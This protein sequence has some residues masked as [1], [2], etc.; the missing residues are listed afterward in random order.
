M[1]S[2][3]VLPALPAWAQQESVSVTFKN[4]TQG[5]VR[6]YWLNNNQ[7]QLYQTLK[8][9]ESAARQTY[10]THVWIVRD[11]SDHELRRVT[12]AANTH[13]VLA[14]PSDQRGTPNVADTN[15][16]AGPTQ[17]Q[18]GETE[19]G[20]K[21][22][23]PA[24]AGAQVPPSSETI[25]A[26]REFFEKVKT[27][28]KNEP[29]TG[30]RH[31]GRSSLKPWLIGYSSHDQNP[32]AV[33]IQSL[34]QRYSKGWTF[35]GGTDY[36]E[37]SM[38]F[39]PDPSKRIVGWQVIS[40]DTY[41][42]EPTYDPRHLKERNESNGDWWKESNGPILLGNVGSIHVKSRFYK[43]TDWS[44]IWYYVDAADYPFD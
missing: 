30:A 8:P 6:V 4:N 5:T 32:V 14:A 26:R 42:G 3:L 21:R 31:A 43:G 22:E 11:A 10:T 17:T 13:E 23:D 9:G 7:E 39:G 34:T 29:D 12:V 33:K 27:A 1:A 15:P 2:V 25:A 44:V 40:H 19:K 28:R 38:R 35:L 41:L 16:K 36:R 18:K 24:K 37:N 20:T